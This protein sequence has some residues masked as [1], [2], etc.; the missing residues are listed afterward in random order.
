MFVSINIYE[1]LNAIGCQK[2]RQF[3]PC[4]LQALTIALCGPPA[5]SQFG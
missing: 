2:Y 4:F 1:G 5:V 3:S